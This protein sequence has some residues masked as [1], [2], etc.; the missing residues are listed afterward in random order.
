MLFWKS[1]L[2]GLLNPSM[3][4]VLTQHSRLHGQAFCSLIRPRSGRRPRL[5][6]RKPLCQI[7]PLLKAV[8]CLEQSKTDTEHTRLQILLAITGGEPICPVAALG[9]LFPYEPQPAD[10]LLFRLNSSGAFWCRRFVTIPK[11]RTAQTG[12]SEAGHSGHSFWK[13]SIATRG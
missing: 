11:N 3:T 12:L 6:K 13:G 5:L 4:S 7:H 2:N 1:L 9:R 8:L 10:A